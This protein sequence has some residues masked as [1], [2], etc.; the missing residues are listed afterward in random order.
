LYEA[1]NGERRYACVNGGGDQHESHRADPQGGGLD[2]CI[3]DDLYEVVPALVRALEEAKGH[4][5]RTLQTKA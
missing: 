5:G 3:V 4:D 2:Y 1:D